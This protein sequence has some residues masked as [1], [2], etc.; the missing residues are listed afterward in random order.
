MGTWLLFFWVV[1]SANPSRAP[2]L[3]A[4][5]LHT[6]LNDPNHRH[7]LPLSFSMVTNSV[8]H[9]ITLVTFCLTLPSLFDIL[10]CRKP[11]RTVFRRGP[12]AVSHSRSVHWA[13]REAIWQLALNHS[14]RSFH[15]LAVWMSEFCS[16]A[17]HQILSGLSQIFTCFLDMICYPGIWYIFKRLRHGFSQLLDNVI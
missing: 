13:E 11:T 10:V 3:K 6:D 2:T 1:N 12:C 4:A 9:D 15:C 5:L 16:S 8:G 7:T 14:T 17:P